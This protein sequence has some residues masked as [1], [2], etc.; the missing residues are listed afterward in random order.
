[1]K[2]NLSVDEE[3]FKKQV[4][5]LRQKLNKIR[6]TGILED[7]FEKCL[8]VLSAKEEKLLTEM[9]PHYRAYAGNSKDAIKTES[10]TRL[11]A[12]GFDGFFQSVLRLSE[13]MFVAG[14][15]DC[16]LQ[17]FQISKR[18]EPSGKE[19]I[20]EEW[21]PPVKAIKEKIS[22]FHRLNKNEILLLGSKGCCYLLSCSNFKQIPNGSGEM[23]IKKIETETGMSWYGQCLS[24]SNNLIA[25]EKEQEELV[26][27]ELVKEKEE[28]RLICH[29]DASLPISNINGMEKTGADDFAVGTKTGEIYFIKRN[30]HNLSI[31]NK[32]KIPDCEI[33]KIHCLENEK[34]Q[35]DTLLSIGNNGKLHIISL[36]GVDINIL[37]EGNFLK[38]NLFDAES[39]KGT[40]VILSEDGI[41]YLLEENFGKWHINKD[42]I[43]EGVFFTDVLKLYPSKYLLMGVEGGLCTLNINRID[44]PQALWDL[45]LY[46]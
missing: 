13:D 6:E 38:G 19:R 4:K 1:M 3:E 36:D 15:T 22:A 31:V 5:D 11:G 9:I 28:Y 20:Q 12:C 14:S 33:R 35:K 43:M 39:S 18:T 23:H 44:T 29:K 40:A 37:D 8:E 30:Y 21:S 2:L 41:L 17:F 26:L 16:A 7:D 10:I 46:Q 27:L 32:I 24:I 34:G 25:A 45:P 42:S